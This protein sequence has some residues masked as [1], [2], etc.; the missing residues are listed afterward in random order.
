MIQEVLMPSSVR[1]KFA[2]QVDPDILARL[3]DLARSE[4]RHVQSLV[5]EALVDLVEKRR[6]GK[7]R[8]NVMAAYRGSHTKFGA[9]YKKL[10]E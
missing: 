8:A 3:R 6:L 10:A 5:E 1:E 9:L 2:T 4:G 7:P